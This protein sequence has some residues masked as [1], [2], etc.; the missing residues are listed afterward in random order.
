[1]RS[2]KKL[3]FF[4]ALLLPFAGGC[5]R[6]SEAT[7]NGVAINK[8]ELHAALMLAQG[9]QVLYRL[10]LQKLILAEANRQSLEISGAEFEGF[11]EEIRNRVSDPAM[12]AVVENEVRARLLLRKILVKDLKE[13]HIEELYDVFGPELAKHKI[14][15][16]TVE[17]EPEARRVVELLRKGNEPETVVRNHCKSERERESGGL[18]GYLNF[19][20]VNLRWG[21]EV[22][23]QLQDPKRG[24][25]AGPVRRTNGYLVVYL[26]DTKAGFEEVRGEIEDLVVDSRR[27]EA[28]YKMLSGANI[29]SVYLLD[30]KRLPQTSL[31]QGEMMPWDYPGRMRVEALPQQ[32]LRETPSSAPPKSE[33]DFSE[34]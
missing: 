4:V 26:S 22:S 16:V 19:G 34:L 6:S 9:Q 20:E 2:C 27:P 17:S 5:Y 29:S 30:P 7:V 14:Y 25:I 8:E 15:A 32:S 31:F 33:D 11:S 13:K 23:Y 12:A 1:M 3:V 21:E 28:I 24:R 18:Q 10:C